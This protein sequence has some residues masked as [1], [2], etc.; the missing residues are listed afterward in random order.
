MVKTCKL[1]IKNPSTQVNKAC[2]QIAKSP[3]TS[4]LLLTGTPIQNNLVELWTLFDWATSGRVLGRK[5][6]FLKK[7][8]EPIERGRD[9]NSNET[10]LKIAEKANEVSISQ[11]MFFRLYFQFLLTA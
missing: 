7:Y 11:R 6:D 10:T 9:K 1:K 5:S 8:A 3:N 2:H 4:R